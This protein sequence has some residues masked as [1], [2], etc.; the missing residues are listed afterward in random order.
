MILVAY[1]G[2]MGFFHT[3]ISILL[4]FSK[5]VFREG[6][7]FKLPKSTRTSEKK[8]KKKWCAPLS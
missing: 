4:F 1:L 6:H 2:A 5:S 8:K 3:V 7:A